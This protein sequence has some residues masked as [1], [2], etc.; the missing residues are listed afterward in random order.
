MIK[1]LT[2]H[3]LEITYFGSVSRTKMHKLHIHISKWKI[4]Q[5]QKT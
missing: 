3:L 1:L 4:T 2:K 5:I